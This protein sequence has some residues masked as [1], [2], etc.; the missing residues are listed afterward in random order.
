MG[1]ESPNRGGAQ[2]GAAFLSYASQDA[3]A[4]QRICDALRAG[5]IEVWLDQSELRGGDAWDRQTR[6]QIHDCALFVPLIS[7][8]SQERLE[9]RHWSTLSAAL[10]TRLGTP[11]VRAFLK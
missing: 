2:R 10:E 9:G 1:V 5:G 4:A 7:Q 3:E 11:R 6:K 8:H